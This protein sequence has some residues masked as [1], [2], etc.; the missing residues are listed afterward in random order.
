MAELVSSIR[1]PTIIENLRSGE[2]L[3][4][5]FQRD[6]VWT[7]AD[8]L[9]LLNSIIDARPVGM[10]TVWEQPDN[11]GLEL[12]HVS[13]PDTPSEA[14]GNSMAYF[15]DPKSRP[16]RFYAVLDGRQRSTAMAMAFGGLAPNDGRRRF[17]GRFFLDVTAT[18]PVERTRFISFSDILKRKLDTRSS[19]V[20]NG[21]IPFEFDPNNFENLEAQWMFYVEAL[22]EHQYYPNGELPDSLE[23]NRR[24]QLL[25]SAFGGIIGTT[26]AVYTVPRKYDLGTICEVFETLNTTGTK[27][28]TVDLIHSWLYAET[29]GGSTEINLRDWLRSLGQTSGAAGWSDPQD[30]PELI[31][32]CVTACYIAEKSPP[33]P[34]KVGG[35][36][37]PVSSVKSG[38]LLATPAEHWRA[39]ISKTELFSDY[40]GSFQFCVAG[41]AFPYRAAPYPVMAAIY[42]ALRWTNSVDQRGWELDRLDRL[43]K[44]FFWRNALSGRYDQG[45]LTKLATDLKSLRDLLDDSLKIEGF[46]EWAKSCSE[47]I[48]RDVG[49]PVSQSRIESFLL[50]PK[51]VGALARAMH[52]FVRSKARVDL[53]D[54]GKSIGYDS[55]IDQVDLHH[56]FPKD[57]VRNNVV[58]SSLADIEDNGRGGVNCVAN[59]TPMSRKSNQSWRANGYCCRKAS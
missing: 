20:T 21:L 39:V 24:S 28:S 12:E 9:S 55:A 45:F 30:R 42:V 3:I 46:G 8:V 35:K 5:V 51:P 1:I 31:A 59:L 17:A 50:D 37:A 41:M 36:V 43:F 32:Q 7:I 13:L 18:D 56:L 33:S 11:S 38:D 29:E 14:S 4:P 26:L 6:F 16:N 57:W 2:Y 40:L 22:R 53:L 34:R 44:A 47:V 49:E 25:K 48:S 19:H 54:P 52:L 27:V 15:G 58:R 23:L 10:I